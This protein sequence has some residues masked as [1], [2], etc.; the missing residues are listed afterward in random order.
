MNP[1][2]EDDLSARRVVYDFFMEE[3]SRTHQRTDWFLIFHAILLE[4]FFAAKPLCLAASIVGLIGVLTAYL[5]LMTG[6]R[7]R[8]LMM[9]L[10]KC[11]ANPALMGRGMSSVYSAVF[12]A[13]KLRLSRVLRWARPVPVY[14]VTTP[15]AF[16]VGWTGLSVWRDLPHWKLT[17]VLAVVCC[18][19]GTGLTCILGVGPDI[20]EDATKSV[21]PEGES[22]RDGTDGES[23][24]S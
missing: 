18:I 20:P 24:P 16:L 17:L 7:Q 13:R 8:W 6:V 11:M 15:A 2:P 9:Q 1:L 14:C 10:G 21:V 12:E 5:W 4:A 22:P 23:P 19:L 3:A